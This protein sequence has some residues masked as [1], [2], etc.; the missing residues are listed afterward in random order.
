MT[1]REW[2]IMCVCKG[3]WKRLLSTYTQWTC[4]VVAVYVKREEDRKSK[5]NK[6]T[7]RQTHTHT[8]TNAQRNKTDTVRAER[9]KE[10]PIAGNQPD[11]YQLGHVHRT[12]GDKFHK[13]CA[14]A[15]VQKNDQNLMIK[16]TNRWIDKIQNCNPTAVDMLL[17]RPTMVTNF[18]HKLRK[19]QT[20]TSHSKW[21]EQLKR[22]V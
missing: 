7:D 22:S 11:D 8:R 9:E 16:L 13:L 10:K 12:E 14:S 19:A 18:W 20:Q 21:S 6:R 15:H 2:E 5:G 1:N 17:L 4:F 3:C